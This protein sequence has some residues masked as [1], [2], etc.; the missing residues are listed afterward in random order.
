MAVT[1]F[2]NITKCMRWRF[3]HVWRQKTVATL[4]LFARFWTSTAQVES[5]VHGA[6]VHAHVEWL[7]LQEWTDA[8]P[9]DYYLHIKS[10]EVPGSLRP[11]AAKVK[12]PH[13]LVV[14][15]S[16]ISDD[17]KQTRMPHKHSAFFTTNHMAFR[18]VQMP[19]VV[20][21]S[22]PRR[23]R[24]VVPMHPRGA[25]GAAADRERAG[26]RGPAHGRLRA[27][28][29]RGR[30]R[31]GGGKFGVPPLV[32]QELRDQLENGFRVQCFWTCGMM[33]GTR[34]TSY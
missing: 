23:K 1:M 16:Y 27:H 9:M 33:R 12:A 25:L 3:V 18:T 5:A 30:A 22:M 21:V 19:T 20:H 6:P 32:Q 17:V 7:R 24:P 34:I 11:E 28:A 8:G 4:I 13:V 31:A 26:L 2:L 15:L 14:N 10:H 29:P